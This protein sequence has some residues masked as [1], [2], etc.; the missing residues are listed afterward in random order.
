MEPRRGRT[1]EPAGSRNCGALR[2]TPWLVLQTVSRPIWTG[3]SRMNNS[4]KSWKSVLDGRQERAEQAQHGFR[5]LAQDSKLTSVAYFSMEFM[6]SDALPIYSGGLG[7]VAGDQLK[8][9]S[10]L[11]VPVIGIGLLYQQG[12]FRQHIDAAGNQIALRPFNEPG[13]LPVQPLRDANGEWL[14]IPIQLPGTPCVSAPGRFRWGGPSS[15]CSIRTI[16]KIC[17]NIAES[18]SELYGGGPE[19]RLQQERILG[20]GGWRLLRALGIAPEVCH[21]NEGHA[22]F[23][24]LERA[25]SW[26]EDTGQ[27]FA[28]ALAV[29]RAGNLFTTHTPVAAGFDRFAPEL[30]GDRMRDY[31][32]R[33]L[34]IPLQ[35]MLALGRKNAQDAAEPFNMAYLAIRGS[36]AVNGVSRLHGQVSRRIFSDIFPR[37]P[38]PEVP[39]SYVTNGIHTPTWDSIEADELWTEVCGKGAWSSSDEKR[40]RGQ[41]APCAGHQ[42]LE[43]AAAEHG[44]R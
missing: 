20:V 33:E 39:V 27:P 10:D 5:R 23:A 17:L 15:T 28:Q 40:D 1:L 25:R 8:A 12:Y 32:E 38:E 43:H 44:N 9:A 35:Q 18:P 14:R 2:R 30:I 26:M 6:L 37:W 29:T 24:V 36:G 3:R 16:R 13:Q 19:L 42:A 21:L 34:G 11:G 7:N 41:N 31:S 4:G 22:A